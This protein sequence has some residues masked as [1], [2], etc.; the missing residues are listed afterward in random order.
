[1]PLLLSRCPLF[2]SDEKRENLIARTI[3]LHLV[4]SSKERESWLN[5]DRS[6]LRRSGG[7]NFYGGFENNPRGKI[8]ADTH[9]HR[10]VRCNYIRGYNR[11]RTLTGPITTSRAAD[12]P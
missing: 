8:G 11:D 7:S 2:H 6:F 9:I 5:R 12:G 3:P 1:M 4:P 10:V